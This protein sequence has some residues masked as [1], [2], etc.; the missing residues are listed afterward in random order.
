MEPLTEFSAYR[1][2]VSDIFYDASFNCRGQFTPESVK[3]LADSIQEHGLQFP[4]VVQPHDQGR[5][6]WRLLAGHRRFKAVTLFLKWKT[7]PAVIRYHLTEHQARILNLTENLERKDLNILEEAQAIRN[8]YPEGVSLRQASADL[9][10]PTRW[11]HTRMRLL[12][13][14]AEVQM[15]A[16]AGLLSAVNIETIVK[17]ET[18][19]ER[20][21]AAAEIIRA[22]EANSKRRYQHALDDRH[23]RP[24]KYRRTKAQ[25]AAMID[26]M[27]Y[28]GIN[29]LPTR[30]LAWAAGGI[31]AEEL[32]ED[33]RKEVKHAPEREC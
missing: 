32:E 28:A 27:I 24:F 20:I 29:G 10:K 1:L 30:A 2:P 11:I 6:A 9:K 12:E 18:E 14:P 31:T 8:L 23:Q 13:L 22:K 3:D 16:A 7:V 33:I 25:I 26:Q 17:L 5:K 4:L 21:K 19:E 15:K